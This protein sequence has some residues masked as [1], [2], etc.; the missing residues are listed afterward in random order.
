MLNVTAVAPELSVIVNEYV[1]SHHVG[2]EMNSPT[3][4]DFGFNAE[5]FVTALTPPPNK[6]CFGLPH[7][8][9]L[10]G[11]QGIFKILIIKHYVYWKLDY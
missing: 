10:L 8:S 5:G 1:I 4:Y 2:S 6:L 9:R 11:V 7:P 3:M